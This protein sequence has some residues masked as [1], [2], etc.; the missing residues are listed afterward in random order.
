MI[1]VSALV[2]TVLAMSVAAASAGDNP[3]LG[4]WTVTEAKMGP[5]VKPGETALPVDPKILHATI[6][7]TATS[8]KGP[9]P[10]GCAKAVY[11]LKTV[12]PDFLFE[13]GLTDPK[14][15]ARALGFTTDTFPA[16]SFG[17]DRPDAD[18][19]MDYALVDAN[20]AVFGLNDR[21]YVMKRTPPR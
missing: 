15:Q 19:E 5:W 8:V 14:P 16:M 20:T 10:L 11:E 12:G 13:G 9:H 3:F 21:V 4:T 18:I 17:C 1:R 7:F 2:V 6:T